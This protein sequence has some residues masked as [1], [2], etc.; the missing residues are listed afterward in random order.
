MTGHSHWRLPIL[1]IIALVLLITG[2]LLAVKLNGGHLVNIQDNSMSPVLKKG[3]LAIATDVPIAAIH[4]D[5]LVAVP[6]KDRSSD[7]VA[8]RIVGTPADLGNRNFQTMGD[9]NA[10]PETFITADK[11][12]GK[13]T[14]RI[15]YIGAVANNMSWTVLGLI[16]VA[17]AAI[18]ALVYEV[19]AATQRRHPHEEED[20]YI[21]PGYNVHKHF[22]HHYGRSR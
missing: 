19:R 13:I 12:M 8:Q 14:Y 16:V 22:P 11:V 20:S 2:G 4:N 18:G 5:D 21:A 1:M 10:S 17:F 3:D 9:N 15:P 6:S 7:V